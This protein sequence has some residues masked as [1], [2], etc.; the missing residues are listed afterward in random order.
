MAE[1]DA[2]A[3]EETPP[4]PWITPPGPSTRHNW[5]SLTP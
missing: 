2:E 1:E 4:M 5:L 3:A